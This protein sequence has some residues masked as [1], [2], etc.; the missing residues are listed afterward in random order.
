MQ[1]RVTLKSQ[2]LQW[3]H[4]CPVTGRKGRLKPLGL[5]GKRSDKQKTLQKI[6]WCRDYLSSLFPLGAFYKETFILRPYALMHTMLYLQIFCA[7]FLLSCLFFF[8]PCN[9]LKT[10]MENGVGHWSSMHCFEF[11][12]NWER[13]TSS[14]IK[15]F[16]V[17]SPEKWV[18]WGDSFTSLP[19]TSDKTTEETFCDI[20]ALKN[21][22]LLLLCHCGSSLIC[23]VLTRREMRVYNANDVV[24]C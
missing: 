8:F 20:E 1:L 5:V 10:K 23:P 7:D 24:W 11:L 21:G 2:N 19:I 22:V 13:R 14:Q 16:L 18:S 6:Y 12:I 3:K 4:L 17:L 15:L 9:F